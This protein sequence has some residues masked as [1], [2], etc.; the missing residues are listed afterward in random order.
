M[1]EIANE[2]PMKPYSSKV[3]V[4]QDEYAALALLYDFGYSYGDIALLWNIRPA[5]AGK[6]IQKWKAPNWK[7]LPPRSNDNLKRYKAE[8]EKV[9]AMRLS[10]MTAH[11]IALDLGL[12]TDQVQR[13][14]RYSEPRRQKAIL[15]RL[16]KSPVTARGLM[17]EM[18]ISE[19]ACYQAL[20]R[21][22][23]AGKI[24]SESVWSLTGQ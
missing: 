16:A 21:L 6:L 20:Y 9:K 12:S 17:A 11:E 18:H 24:G 7:M 14:F 1:H 2:L 13:R 3:K 22:K 5:T 15:D 8:A 19:S 4:T 23:T 10:G